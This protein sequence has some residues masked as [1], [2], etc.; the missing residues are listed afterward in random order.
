MGSKNKENEVSEVT[1]IY[2]SF[3]NMN[4]SGETP[5]ILR[6]SDGADCFIMNGDEVETAINETGVVERF[7]EI[8]ATPGLSLSTV[9]DEGFLDILRE[10]DLLNEYERDNTFSAYLSEVLMESFY[11]LELFETS[12]EKYD[13][14]R[15]FCSIE[16]SAKTTVNQLMTARPNLT[17]WTAEINIDN[18]TVTLRG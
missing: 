3:Q 10:N 4:L 6:L 9:Y 14:K 2:G 1:S 16:A 13:H 5:V 11:D 8:L 17:G 18:T 7:G 15:G 12:I